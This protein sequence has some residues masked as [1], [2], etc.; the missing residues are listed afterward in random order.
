MEGED[1]NDRSTSII[2]DEIKAIIKILQAKKSQEL[3]C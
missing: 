1:I 3:H 2:S